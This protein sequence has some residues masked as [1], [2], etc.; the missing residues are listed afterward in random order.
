MNVDKNYQNDTQEK[1]NGKGKGKGKGKNKGSEE[2]M[3][4]QGIGKDAKE[5]VASLIGMHPPGFI[6]MYFVC[7]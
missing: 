5:C 7:N 4:P 6:G 2:I 1:E 3:M